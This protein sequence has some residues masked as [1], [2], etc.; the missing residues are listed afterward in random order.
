MAIAFVRQ[1]LTIYSVSLVKFSICFWLSF[2][3]LWLVASYD[4][5]CWCWTVLNSADTLDPGTHRSDG[6]HLLLQGVVFFFALWDGSGAAFILGLIG[7]HPWAGPSGLACA[8]G[9]ALL[10]AFLTCELIGLSAPTPP[11]RC[12]LGPSWVPSL[13][14]HL[15]TR[16]RE[17]GRSGPISWDHCASLC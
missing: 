15:N 8:P 12:T 16:G 7:P 17:L 4:L 6:N 10:S 9:S 13:H 5:P 11:L 1:F 3:N 2:G 14:H